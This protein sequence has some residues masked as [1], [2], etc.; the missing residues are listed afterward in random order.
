ML[1]VSAR[2]FVLP[3]TTEQRIEASCV[4]AVVDITKVN[5][6]KGQSNARVVQALSGVKVGEI[7][8]IWDDWQLDS[9]GVES[10]FNGRDAS[11]DVG[12]RYLVYLV[13]NNKGRMVTVQ[14]S[15][16][17]LKVVGEQVEKEG[18]EGFESLSDKLAYIRAVLAK[19]KKKQN[20][21]EQATPRKLS[22]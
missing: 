20:K 14:S 8:S 18:E 13:K 4:I 10:R 22:E 7:I 11:F 15:L 19:Q 6:E 2:A 3:L 17:C 9:K 12:K 16:D 1:G 5:D 21:S